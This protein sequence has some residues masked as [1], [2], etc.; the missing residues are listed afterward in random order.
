MGKRKERGMADGKVATVIGICRSSICMAIANG[1][2]YILMAHTGA[3]E[4]PCT[5]TRSCPDNVQL[6]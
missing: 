5:R 2:S 6:K 3:L 4:G 1:R